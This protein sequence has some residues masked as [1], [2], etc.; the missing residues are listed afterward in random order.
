M[1]GLRELA[2]DDPCRDLATTILAMGA[3]LEQCRAKFGRHLN[4]VGHRLKACGDELTA[5]Q[6]REI[7][8]HCARVDN[9]IDAIK[10][11]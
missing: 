1:P 3:H 8:T 7:E 11:K 5:E 10:G 9:V 2:A 4:D 6:I